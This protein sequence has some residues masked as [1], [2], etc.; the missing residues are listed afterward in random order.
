MSLTRRHTKISDDRGC[1]S[2]HT[3]QTF[4]NLYA[5]HEK[6]FVVEHFD[7]EDFDSENQNVCSSNAEENKW[8][9]GTCFSA[10]KYNVQFYM[11]QQYQG[12]YNV[13]GA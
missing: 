10:K 8:I 4:R 5:L 13:V 2:Y 3:T 12:I 6:K 11:W 9:N 7:S 1:Y